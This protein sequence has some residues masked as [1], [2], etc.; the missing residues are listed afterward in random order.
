ML[1]KKHNIVSVWPA[2][3]IW[4]TGTRRNTRSSRMQFRLR[5][6]FVSWPCLLR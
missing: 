2:S 4:F 1:F 3:C 6:D 5:M